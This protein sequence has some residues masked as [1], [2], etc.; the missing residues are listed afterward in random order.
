[1]QSKEA[2]ASGSRFPGFDGLRLAAALSV[3]F[4]HAF[5]IAE[6]SDAR[7]PLRHLLGQKNVVGLYGVFTFFVISGFLLTR[8]LSNN[9]RATQFSLNRVLRIVPGFLFCALVTSFLIGPTV[10]PLSLKSY[11][12]Q[13]ETY[14]YPVSSLTCLCDSRVVAPFQFAAR[15]GRLERVRNGS[16]WTLSYEVL[17]YVFLLWLWALLRKPVLIAVAAAA[18]AVVSTSYPTSMPG[19]AY[20]MP[21]FAS[22]VIMYAVH[23]RFGT[24]QWIACVSLALIGASAFLRLQHYAF[25]I[26]GAYLIVFL[27]ERPNLGSRFASRWGDLSY[28]CYLFGWPVEQLVQQFTGIVDGWQLFVVSAPVV[29]LCGLVSWWI[30][31]R[32]CIAAKSVVGRISARSACFLGKLSN[33]RI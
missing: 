32:P 10:T 13:S 26:F 8:S 6:G 28:G 17:S 5:S 1:M 14:V 11:Y 18:T 15:T 2:F 16:L 20:T 33:G 22:G 24:R 21:F 19:I 27:A 7:E 3:L 29:L 30:V 9:P 31:E 12:L 25:A 23:Q 4:S